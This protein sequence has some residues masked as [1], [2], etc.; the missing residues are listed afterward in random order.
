MIRHHTA[1]AARQSLAQCGSAAGRGSSSVSA[2]SSS[3]PTP[4]ARL[5]G[6]RVAPRAQPPLNRA[7]GAEA[8]AARL[9]QQP[10]HRI[11]APGQTGDR[12]RKPEW[13]RSETGSEKGGTGTRTQLALTAQA[14][15]A[16]C[17]GTPA[18]RTDKTWKGVNRHSYSCSFGISCSIAFLRLCHSFLFFRPYSRKTRSRCFFPTHTSPLPSVCV[19]PLS[20]A[21]VVSPRPRPGGHWCR[22]RPN[23]IGQSQLIDRR[24]SGRP[25]R[26]PSDHT[27]RPGCRRADCD[28]SCPPR[29]SR[30]LASSGR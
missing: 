2:C 19:L 22:R 16:G 29:D 11:S 25:A 3:A 26:A 12:P 30:P 13:T 4:S 27:R 14:N 6:R 28:S 20:H 1:R 10:S 5:V 15:R 7:N 18:T 9:Q 23:R 21:S 24:W 17:L 8:V